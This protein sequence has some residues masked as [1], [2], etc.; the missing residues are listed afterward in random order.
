MA[1][2]LAILGGNK[3]AEGLP[4]PANFI[5]DEERKLVNEVLDSNELSGFIATPGKFFDGGSMVQRLQNEW[6]ETLGVKHAIAVNS[7][8]SGL[9]AACAACEIGPGDEVI[10]PPLTMAA[11][12]EAIM[13]CN[14]VPIFCDTVQDALLADPEDIKR[15][16]TERTKAIMVVHLA[17]HTCDM[18]PIMEFAREKGLFVI[19]DNAQAPGA[20]Y[21]G[22]QAGCIGDLG[23]FSLNRHKTIQSGEGGVVTTNNDDLA[24]KAKLFRNHGDKVAEAYGYGHFNHVGLNN[25]MTELEAAVGLAQFRKLESLTKPRIEYAEIINEGI[26]DIEG[27]YAPY[28]TDNCRHVYYIYHMR[29]EPETVGIPLDLFAKAVEAEGFPIWSR[30][31]APIYTYPI[32]QNLSAYGNTG[33]PFK[34]PLYKGKVSYRKG[35]CPVAEQADETSLWTNMTSAQYKPE[36]MKLLVQA[37]KKVLA[38]KEELLEAAKH[39]D[40]L[41]KSFITIG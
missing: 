33:C 38:N 30:Y 39:E 22:K 41:A 17:G 36:H 37:M 7:A 8:T 16:Y 32:Y 19:E 9:H 20:T 23:V 35:I 15:K 12:A 26:K 13:A 5:K 4:I 1:E 6:A 25:R 3:T 29:Y 31:G 14:G 2:K 27:I 21:K 18:D 11:S 10:L 28:K 40:L 24:M 34:C